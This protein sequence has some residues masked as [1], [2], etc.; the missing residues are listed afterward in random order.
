M[1]DYFIE[2]LLDVYYDVYLE[3]CVDE[4]K[5]EIPLSFIEWIKN[6][7][8]EEITNLF[9]IYLEELNKEGLNVTEN[10]SKK[11]HKSTRI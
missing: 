2:P 9:R 6:H 1:K 11:S 8:E 7:G 5:G 3:E 10:K 4:E